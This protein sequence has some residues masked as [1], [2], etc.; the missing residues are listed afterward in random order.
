M[1]VSV[2]LYIKR[3]QCKQELGDTVYSLLMVSF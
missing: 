1:A 2:G 3:L